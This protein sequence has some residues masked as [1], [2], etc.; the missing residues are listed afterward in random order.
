MLDKLKSLFRRN[1]KPTELEIHKAFERIST[2]WVNELN[3]NDAEI[4]ALD[5]QIKAGRYGKTKTAADFLGERVDALMD[6]M[7][8]DGLTDLR[9]VIKYYNKFYPK[10]SF[11]SSG[12]VA[13][14]CEKYSLQFD[15]IEKYLG[16]FS[17]Q[18]IIAKEFFPQIADEDD[19]R[20]YYIHEVLKG[21]NLCTMA[22]FLKGHPY[23]LINVDEC[24]GVYNEGDLLRAKINGKLMLSR[25]FKVVGYGLWICAP[26]ADFKP[27]N[28]PKMV[29]NGHKTVMKDPIILK[30][31]R[32]GYLL[33]NMLNHRVGEMVINS[34]PQVE[35]NKL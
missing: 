22:E 14:L 23:N 24:E 10:Y 11:V 25:Q 21:Q 32:N 5:A 4:A 17:D 33:V 15:P 1:R 16:E 18:N 26:S 2:D 3:Q 12:H 30:T 34:L 8:K 35:K 27:A 6:E 13:T 31:V 29:K 20:H 28:A 7:K 9:D 19:D